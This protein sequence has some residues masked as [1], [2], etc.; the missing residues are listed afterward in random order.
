MF[1]TRELRGWAKV[2]FLAAVLT[3][4]MVGLVHSSR[5]GA[6]LWILAAAVCCTALAMLGHEGSH[7]SFSRSPA[8]NALLVYLAFPLFT[9]LGGLYWRENTIGGTTLIRTSKASIRTSSRFRSRR[10][11]EVTRR[12]R[13]ASAGSSACFSAGCSGR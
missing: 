11:A 4:C 13:R 5:L 8:R 12:A 1:E 10:R 2:V 9:G 6:P 3:G 7:R